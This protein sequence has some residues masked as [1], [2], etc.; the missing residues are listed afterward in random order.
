MFPLAAHSDVQRSVASNLDAG[1]TARHKRKN[2]AVVGISFAVSFP[3][4]SRRSS[5]FETVHVA[6]STGETKYDSENNAEPVSCG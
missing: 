4:S 2:A 6:V 5:S 1:S 3:L